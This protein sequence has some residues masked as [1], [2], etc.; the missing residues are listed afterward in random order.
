MRCYDWWAEGVN[1]YIEG[2][3]IMGYFGGKPVPSTVHN[4][5]QIEEFPINGRY[6]AQGYK[7]ANKVSCRWYRGVAEVLYGMVPRR[8]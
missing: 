8:G 1:V 6:I 7:G 3:Y 2:T 5:P 4:S